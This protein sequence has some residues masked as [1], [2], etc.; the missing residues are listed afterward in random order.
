[1]QIA[2]K[3]LFSVNGGSRFSISLL[4]LWSGCILLLVA[5]AVWWNF[6]T[7]INSNGNHSAST[8]L[9]VS[10]TVTNENMGRP[11]STVFNSDDIALLRTAPQVKELG[12]LTS[13]HFPAYALVGGKLAFSTDLPLESMPDIF[14]DTLPADWQWQPGS[15]VVPVVLS[16]QF[17]DIY[18]YVFAPSQGLPQLSQ[19]SVKSIGITLKA[20]NE[21]FIAHVTG[22]SDRINSV[23]VPQSFMEYG[24]SHYAIPGTAA[25]PSRLILKVGDPNDKSF[26]QFLE[27]HN[28]YTSD[29][30][31]RWN[32]IR[33]IVE[34]VAGATG[35][36]A[37]I[38]LG[39]SMLVLILFIELTVS[40]AKQSIVLLLE[41]G[42]SP[43]MLSSL[44]NKR[45]L[46]R[47][48]LTLVSALMLVLVL[49]FAVSKSVTDSGLQLPAIPGSPVWAV[50]IANLLIISAVITRSVRRVLVRAN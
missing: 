39:I 45:F 22:F 26:G 23:L 25:G 41:L 27:Q 2:A 44:L 47:I 49:Q 28:Y 31:L 7:L 24:N 13:N 37:L 43:A 29:Q 40:R 48:V 35:V 42:Y 38:I 30:N 4:A 17:L 5:V 12:I 19:S 16:T 20:G 33:S 8:F 9:I 34:V 11:G 21:T 18:N 15:R 46:P 32:K 6:N 14:L 36:I 3:L 50:F 1:M 10:K